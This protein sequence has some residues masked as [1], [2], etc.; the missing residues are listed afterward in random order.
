M[1]RMHE[2]DLARGGNGYIDPNIRNRKAV[3]HGLRSTFR[4]WAAERGYDRDM[5]EIQLSHAVGSA[6]ERSYR[7][8]DMM[9]RRRAMMEAWGR[10]VRGEEEHSLANMEAIK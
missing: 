2:A 10:F 7:R 8:T 1:I 9:E 4:D 3:P 5:A 6:T